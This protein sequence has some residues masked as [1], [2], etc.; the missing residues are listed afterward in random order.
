M[1]WCNITKLPGRMSS[2]K[3]K[4]LWLKRFRWKRSMGLWDAR[5]KPRNLWLRLEAKSRARVKPLLQFV[6]NSS[7]HQSPPS[8]KRWVDIRYNIVTKECAHLTSA[9]VVVVK[10]W[11]SWAIAKNLAGR[12]VIE[13]HWLPLLWYLAQHSKPLEHNTFPINTIEV[14]F[15]LLI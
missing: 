6:R 13:C 10:F 4:T 11:K 3:H 14:S 5:R 1:T 8:L 7:T 2:F 9:S 12:Y 15:S